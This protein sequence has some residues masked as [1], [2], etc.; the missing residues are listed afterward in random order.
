MVKFPSE[1]RIKNIEKDVAKLLKDSSPLGLSKF[2]DKP[3][4]LSEAKDMLN[5]DS[6]EILAAKKFFEERKGS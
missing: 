1:I 6:E 2:N 4:V 5:T 3:D